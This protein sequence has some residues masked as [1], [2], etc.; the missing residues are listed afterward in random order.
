MK[1]FLTTLILFII[2]GRFC[3]G[4]SIDIE[5]LGTDFNGIF[6]S[7]STII[8]YGKYGNITYSNDLG[9]SWKQS[10]VGYTNDILKIISLEGKFYALSPE[11][12]FVSDDQAKLGNQQIFSGRIIL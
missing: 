5:M 4:N 11:N 2:T 7:G 10:I 3:F 1:N 12:I 6:H 8:I 9:V